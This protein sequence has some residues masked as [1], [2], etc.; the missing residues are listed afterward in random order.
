LDVRVLA[1]L[2]QIDGADYVGARIE[3]GIGH[4]PPHI[5]LR[6]V[7]IENARLE[8]LDQ[9]SA[10]PVADVQPMHGYPRVDIPLLAGREIINNVN[11]V[12]TIDIRIDNVGRDKARAAGNDDLQ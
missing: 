7:M 11:L 10:A 3:R 9:L 5:H 12:A 8:L 4:R 2:Q 6:R 1:S